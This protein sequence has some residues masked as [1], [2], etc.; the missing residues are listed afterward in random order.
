MGQVILGYGYETLK[1]FVTVTESNR[2]E[3]TIYWVLPFTGSLRL[4]VR[5][6]HQ[7]INGARGEKPMQVET[8]NRHP[9]SWH[10]RQLIQWCRQYEWG[11]YLYH[12]PNETTGGQGWVARNRQMGCRKGVPDLCLPIP[13]QGY[14][15]LYIELKTDKGRPSKNQKRWIHALSALGYRAEVCQGWEA[16]RDVLIEYMEV[17][18]T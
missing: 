5:V 8:S 17:K 6:T 15:G 7:Y 14:H 12:I 18:S 9:E 10:Q 3:T 1:V 11:Q 16:A 4:P 13:M 2:E